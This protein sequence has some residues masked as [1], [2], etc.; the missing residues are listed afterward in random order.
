[1]NPEESDNLKKRNTSSEIEFV[2]FKNSQQTEV[3]NWLAS[4]GNS[5]THTKS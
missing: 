3:R 5:T 2:I 1:M 4:L